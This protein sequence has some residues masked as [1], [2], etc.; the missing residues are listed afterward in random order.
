ME[1]VFSSL[2]RLKALWQQLEQAKPKSPE[3][4]ALTKQIRAES[5]TYMALVESETFTRRK[6][7]NDS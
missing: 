4:Q 2:K 3:D 6:K 7:P 1:R 5:H